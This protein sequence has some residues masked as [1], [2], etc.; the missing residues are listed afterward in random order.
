[1]A[2][3]GFASRFRHSQSVV[4]LPFHRRPDRFGLGFEDHGTRECGHSLNSICAVLRTLTCRRKLP[5]DMG[6]WR[7]CRCK[8]TG[9]RTVY[10]MQA[11]EPAHQ[12]IMQTWE[13]EL[14][15]YRRDAVRGPSR[16]RGDRPPEDPQVRGMLPWIP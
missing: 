15:A 6:N 5:L 16:P 9:P 11:F 12:D 8:I 1:M 3:E 4:S 2:I 14:Q 10:S 7:S 13:E